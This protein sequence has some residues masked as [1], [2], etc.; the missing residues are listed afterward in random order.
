MKARTDHEG[1]PMS[2]LAYFFARAAHVNGTLDLPFSRTRCVRVF[3]HGFNSYRGGSRLAW[4]LP[5][6][7]HES[8][9]GTDG[10]VVSS[11]FGIGRF[12]IEVYWAAY[13]TQPEEAA[14]CLCGAYDHHYMEC[15]DGEGE[16]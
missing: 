14:P 12:Q 4:A 3:Y 7:S 11:T 1:K 16:E 15:Q 6:F 10:D 5:S 9:G 2:A 13:R 8:D